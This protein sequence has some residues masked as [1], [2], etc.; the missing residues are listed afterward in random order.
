MYRKAGTCQGVDAIHDRRIPFE[1]RH[2][3]IAFFEL[4]PH[5]A[6]VCLKWFKAHLLFDF[7]VSLSLDFALSC[8]ASEPSQPS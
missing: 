7:F 3:V 4:I 8:A 5:K 1:F 2:T 6:M